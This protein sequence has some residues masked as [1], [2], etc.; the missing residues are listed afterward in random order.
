M[1]IQ[2]FPGHMAKAGKLIKGSIKLADVIVEVADARVPGSSLNPDMKKLIGEKKRLIVLNKCDLADPSVNR[3][4]IRHFDQKGEKA[5]LTDSVTGQGIEEVLRYAK[6]M[7]KIKEHA[8]K[9]KGRVHRP[10]RIMV[11]G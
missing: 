4:W 11:V 6:E 5:F 2:W 7:T 10:S 9:E 3:L 1:D 8:E